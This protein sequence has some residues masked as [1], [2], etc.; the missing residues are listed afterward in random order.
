MRSRA[1]R[2]GLSTMWLRSPREAAQ[3]AFG[4]RGGYLGGKVPFGFRLGESGELVPHEAEQEAICEMVALR[5]QGK[6]L[7]A[8]AEAV[9]ATR[10]AM[11][12]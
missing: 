4:A 3:A 7:R 2:S 12:A 8:I 6:A 1:K 5:A 9:Q 11:R 10:S